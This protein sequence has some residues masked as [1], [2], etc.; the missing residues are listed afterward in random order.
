MS[1]E[2]FYSR[3]EP[4]G[5]N[6]TVESAEGSLYFRTSGL[7]SSRLDRSGVQDLVETLTDWLELTEPKPEPREKTQIG[8]MMEAV[9]GAHIRAQLENPPYLGRI[10][11][12]DDCRG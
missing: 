2:L 10:S 6:L 5:E 7:G 12:E 3:D 11:K 1:S 8:L 9:Y 4:I